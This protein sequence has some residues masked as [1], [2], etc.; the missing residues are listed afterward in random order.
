MTHRLQA[1][2]CVKKLGIPKAKLNPKGVAPWQTCHIISRHCRRRNCAGTSPRMHRQPA[3]QSLHRA[4]R[5]SDCKLADCH[6]VARA[7]APGPEVRRRVHV[8]RL[9]HAF[10]SSDIS[11]LCQ[12]REWVRQLSSSAF[13]IVALPGHNSPKPWMRPRTSGGRRRRWPCRPWMMQVAHR[14]QAARGRSRR[15]DA[16]RPGWVLKRP[17]GCRTRSTTICRHRCRRH[18]R[19]R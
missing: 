9:Q 12:G 18:V 8:H 14:R 5:V 15:P 4:H 6:A 7:Q 11:R 2:Y 13:S 19:A 10:S 1:T 17:N 3:G 16:R